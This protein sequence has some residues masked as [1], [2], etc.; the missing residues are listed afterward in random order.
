MLTWTRCFI[1]PRWNLQVCYKR[2][3]WIVTHL[4]FWWV[5]QIMTNRTE[6][7]EL[8]VSSTESAELIQECSINHCCYSRVW[9]LWVAGGG[10]WSKW[11]LSFDGFY[12][13]NIGEMK[14][15]T[16]NIL[17][18]ILKKKSR[19]CDWNFQILVLRVQSLTFFLPDYQFEIYLHKTTPFRIKTSK[20]L[21]FFT[22][23]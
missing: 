4:C 20:L 21:L 23:A 10:K 7:S 5:Y 13:D 17:G 18:S 11:K 19:L 8:H 1:F 15:K 22:S 14:P 9:G 3:V 16:L 2:Q 6:G 12:G